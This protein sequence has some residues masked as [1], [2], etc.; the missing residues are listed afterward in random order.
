[1]AG[2]VTVTAAN[3]LPLSPAACSWEKKIPLAKSSLEKAW[4][5]HEIGRCYLQLD[6]AEAAKS[7]GEKSLQAADEEGD[8]KWQLHAT[9]L[10]AEAQG[11]GVGTGLEKP[12]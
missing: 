1:M 8:V 4:L 3:C 10:V 2:I 6:K 12:D 11:K 7:Y 9:V 5:F